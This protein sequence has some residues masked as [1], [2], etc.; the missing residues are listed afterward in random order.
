[1]L[2]AK[3][4]QKLK[5][6]AK[7]LYFKDIGLH[8]DSSFPQALAFVS[9][10]HSDHFAPH[11]HIICSKPTAILLEERFRV[12]PEKIVAL[13]WQT[14][15]RMGSYTL[16]LYPAGH[17]AGSAMILISKENTSL[18]YT[19]D[20]KMRKSLTAE[21]PV[22]PKADILVME[23]TFGLPRYQFPPSEQIYQDLIQ[24][25]EDTL[26]DDCAP[27]ILGYS[28]GKAQEAHAILDRA[29]IPV[30]LHK[31]VYDM[32]EA[33]N[34]LDIYSLT[35]P[36]KFEGKIPAGHALIAPPN[37]IR[38]RAL[39]TLKKKRSVMLSGW[40]LDSS[41]IYRYQTDAVIPLSDHADFPELL[42]TVEKVNPF[43]IYTLHGSTREFAT[44]LR[45][46]GRE[47]WSIY[48]DEQLELLRAENFTKERLQPDKI[49]RPECQLKK[50]SELLTT[51]QKTGSRLQKTQLISD[52]IYPLAD[53]DLKA[54]LNWLRETRANRLPPNVIKQSILRASSQPLAIYKTVSAHQ[55]DSARTG[56]ILLEM[57]HSESVSATKPFTFTQLNNQLRNIHDT[58]IQIEKIR[59]F[60][61]LL[62]SVHPMEGET[63][64]RIASGG[65]RSGVKDGLLEDALAKAFN[66][67]SETLRRAHML[68]GSLAAT[69]ILAKN[70]SLNK[71]QLHVG[72]AIK[73]MLASP[74][75]SAETI[76]DW[77][78]N[79][80]TESPLWV[81]EKYDG[82]RA[83]LHVG[84]NEVHL[85]SR[86]LKLLD[87]QFPELIK[88]AYSL[89]QC[90]LD[91]EIIAFIHGESPK[92]MS[93]HDIQKRLGKKQEKILQ[94]DLF[95]GAAVPVAFIAFDCIWSHAWIQKNPN[96]N[97]FEQS[98]IIRR[99][100]LE[101]LE[102]AEP[103][104]CI[105][106]QKISFSKSDLL[107]NAFK[108]ALQRGNEGLMIKDQLSS[109]LPGR[110]GRAWMKLKGVM[111]TLDCVVIAAQQGHGKRAGLLSD[112]TFAVRDE[113][114]GNLLT[115]GKAY[116]GL[117]D[118][119]IEELT[120]HFQRT[121]IGKPQRK[122]HEVKAEVVLEIAFDK[123]APSKRHNSGLAL[124]FP[125]IKAIRHDKTLDEI[126]TLSTARSLLQ[127]QP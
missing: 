10:A 85:Y 52:F 122:I 25:T 82:I 96:L 28:L 3:H 81:E 73:P 15:H 111:P 5:F 83:Q 29:G 59:R 35:K 55:N 103:F 49:I 127:H 99:K 114:S 113:E 47:A 13:G 30:V 39:R 120:I 32:A 38:S 94:G 54:L 101:Q 110:R 56:R 69:A 18:L 63:I 33:H 43:L 2:V 116:S 1:M 62:K 97:L 78:K 84:E 26:A 48:G 76:R 125:R 19:G 100:E 106:L 108:N 68:T 98:L 17:I 65:I 115:L 123:I 121:T 117:T 91:G 37:M 36:I 124:R 88:S 42:A 67:H 126:D 60:S 44:E 87:E 112:Y 8:L 40:A 80:A 14:E 92:V 86:D 34:L 6:D 89:P 12:D 9:H 107:D 45:A 93:F 71:A 24:F 95:G 90:I 57:Q 66:A 4:C 109:Y 53:R 118:E 102:L 41:A 50:L 27:V 104:Q 72:T 21:A 7:N 51:L 75:T 105:H 46:R 11:Q 74:A 64:I 58:S 23:S 79:L 70:N 61:E 20:F 16:K 119:E 77:H 22:F 31:A